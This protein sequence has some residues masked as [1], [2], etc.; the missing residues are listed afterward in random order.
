MRSLFDSLKFLTVHFDLFLHE[1][2]RYFIPELDEEIVQVAVSPV[3]IKG[4]CTHFDPPMPFKL[5]T[6]KV[7]YLV[8][9]LLTRSWFGRWTESVSDTEEQRRVPVMGNQE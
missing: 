2:E 9:P 4:F 8:F 6:R 1:A 7:A 3:I 5:R